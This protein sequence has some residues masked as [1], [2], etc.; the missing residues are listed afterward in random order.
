MN[1]EFDKFEDVGHT[2]KAYINLWIG[3]AFMGK[4]TETSE[5]DKVVKELLE[6][7]KGGAL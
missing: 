6:S 2:L 5:I 3:K 4:R 7:L 1:T